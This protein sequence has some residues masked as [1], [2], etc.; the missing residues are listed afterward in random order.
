MRRFLCLL[1]TMVIGACDGTDDKILAN[2]IINEQMSSVQSASELKSVTVEELVN[3][4]FKLQSAFSSASSFHSTGNHIANGLIIVTAAGAVIKGVSDT[5]EF[6]L[7]LLG[8]NEL[9]A[10]TQFNK[11]AEA[12][13][14][15]SNE[16]LC[17]NLKML[18]TNGNLKSGLTNKINLL[19][20]MSASHN[21]LRQR[22]S[23]PRV[24]LLPFLDGFRNG[25]TDI[26]KN[27]Q[28]QNSVISL[29]IAALEKNNAAMTELLD[30]LVEVSVS[31]G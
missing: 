27:A 9:L 1:T 23:R 29:K 10:Y 22:L 16:A 11:S 26:L 4:N 30:C 8:V 20:A 6:I 7:G 2:D 25:S 19:T 14:I 3:A 31:G 24:Q 15:A 21:N 17:M 12:Y 18:N 5:D 28:I 13:R